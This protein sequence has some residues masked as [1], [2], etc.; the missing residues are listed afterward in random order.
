MQIKSG[1]NACS[2]IWLRF[3]NANENLLLLLY[4]S[5]EETYR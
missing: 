2:K 5:D 1:P 3:L 4:Y